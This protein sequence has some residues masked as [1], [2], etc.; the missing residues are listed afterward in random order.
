MI[1]ILKYYSVYFDKSENFTNILDAKALLIYGL[2]T[3]SALMKQ[4]P[5]NAY[6]KLFK[7]KRYT[8][9]PTFE[10]KKPFY[11]CY[12]S[13]LYDGREQVLRSWSIKHLWQGWTIKAQWLNVYPLLSQFFL[14]LYPLSNGE[15]FLKFI[16][17]GFDLIGEKTNVL[18][19]QLC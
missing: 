5:T 15:S 17:L 9:Y 19:L 10:R 6:V 18:C 12:E 8:V 7:V 14:L 4:S 2:I 11:K 16:S 3:T 13:T 1:K